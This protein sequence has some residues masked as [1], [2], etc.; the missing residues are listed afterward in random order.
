M[1]IIIYIY[2]R[3]VF[4]Y[5]IG[6]FPNANNILFYLCWNNSLWRSGGSL[7]VLLLH[8]IPIPA[9]YTS[10]TASEWMRRTARRRRAKELVDGWFPLWRVLGNPSMGNL[11]V[12]NRPLSSRRRDCDDETRIYNN[13]INNL[14][15]RRSLYMF[16][17]PSPISAL[18]LFTP[19][20]NYPSRLVFSPPAF[21]IIYTRNFFFFFYGPIEFEWLLFERRPPPP[22]ILLLI[23]INKNICK[24][25]HR[26]PFTAFDVPSAATDWTSGPNLDK[27]IVPRPVHEGKN[28]FLTNCINLHILLTFYISHS[29]HQI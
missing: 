8:I 27:I 5:Y 4:I 3:T 20:S 18:R 7:Y 28:N 25:T 19:R 14:L 29:I 23:N 22:V 24:K 16:I 12:K 10:E 26:T 15:R 2:A 21:I 1:Y 9:L 17:V 13:N 11:F 6:I